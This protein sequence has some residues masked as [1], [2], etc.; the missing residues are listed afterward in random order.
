M[1]K[2][3]TFWRRSPNTKITTRKWLPKKLIL[4]FIFHTYIRTSIQST[5]TL[6]LRDLLSTKLLLLLLL[7]MFGWIMQSNFFFPS[8][9][10]S[11]NIFLCKQTRKHKKNFAFVHVQ[12]V[13]CLCVVFFVRENDEQKIKGFPSYPH[14]FTFLIPT[15][16]F[17][18]FFLF[19]S[20]ECVCVCCVLDWGFVVVLQEKKI[21]MLKNQLRI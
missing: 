11:L 19:I 1:K 17:S 15:K 20:Y 16:R 4:Y 3:K 13:C 10:N 5:H 9:H 18:S 21:W 8:T 6:W 12:H 14:T 7:C 2:K